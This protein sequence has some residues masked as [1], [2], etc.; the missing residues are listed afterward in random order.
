M[1]TNNLIENVPN[2]RAFFFHHLLGAFDSGHIAALFE[3]VVN[4]RFEQFERHFLRQPALMQPQ[5]RT[6][7]DDRTAGIVDSFAEEVLTEATR[8]PLEHVAQRF[9]WAAVLAGYRPATP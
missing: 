6:D 3:F 8:F 1:F 5:L 2:F 4:E 9:K 7:D